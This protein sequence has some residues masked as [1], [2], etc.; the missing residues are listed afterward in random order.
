MVPE[1]WSITK[2]SDLADVKRGAGSQYLTYV[3]DPDDGIRLIRIGDFLGDN[4]KYVSHTP[5]MN[6]FILKK[7]DILIAGT[8]AT[9][10]IT[11]EVPEHFEGFAF[12]YNAPRIRPKS[13]VDKVFLVNFLKSNEITKQQRSLF[14]GNAQPFLDTKA[15]GGFRISTPP[16]P[17][18]RKIADILATWDA[19]IE[20]T[21]AL[22][23]TAK[24]QKRA[25]MQSLLTGKRRFPDFEGQ[26]WKEV[27]LGETGTTVSGGTPDSTVASN[28][29]G[30][31]HWAT[32]TDITKLTSRFI[33]KT[34]RMITESGLKGSS[35]K[36]V[37]SGTILICTRATIGEMAIATGPICTNQGFKNLVLSDAFDSDFIFY[38]LQ[39]FKK[40]LIRYACGSTFLELSKKDFDKR[41][42]LMPELGEQRRIAAVLNDAEDQIAEHAQSITKL[43]TE[44][45]ALMQQLLTG[46]RRVSL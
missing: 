14:T 33:R 19:A 44:K 28:W 45:K 43:R 12:S 9:A 7:G 2:L 39:F 37:P 8:G 38:L 29:D 34:A 16:L 4:P 26:P 36:L 5:D 25:L 32:P 10:G 17:E 22:L 35:A 3:D 42:F 18:Q 23:A 31:I 20:K 21:E 24:D 46:K 6:R 40:D 11:F 41:S 1:G 27:R 30:D 13:S 15:I